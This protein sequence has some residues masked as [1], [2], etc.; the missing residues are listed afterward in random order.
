MK[1]LKLVFVTGTRADYG[2][3]KS[4][5]LL[6]DADKDIEAHVYVT[7]MHLLPEYGFT[8]EDIV[9][10]GYN[11][12]HIPGNSIC[13][14]KMDEN[15][16]H[17]ILH[18]SPYVREI[19]PDFI[20][21]HGDRI[22]PLAGS[23]VGIL[24]NVR[25]AHI[26]GGEITGT[27]D[28][29][30]RHAISKLSHLHFVANEESKIRLL[31]L[32]E[33]ENSIYAIGSPDIDI[34]LSDA[35]PSVT[36]V[37]AKYGIEFEEYSICIYHPVTTSTNLEHETQEVVSALLTSNKN[38]IVIYPNND[39]G[40]EIIRHSLNTL[41]E[42]ERFMFFKSIPFEYFLV[43]LKNSE[44]IIGNSSAGVREACVYGV[45]AIDIG[46]R[47]NKR[48]VPGALKNIQHTAEDCQSIL[49]CIAQI[50][51][52]RH[53]S[54]YFGNGQSA[55]LFLDIIKSSAILEGDLQKTFV[56]LDVTSDAIRNYINEV[57]F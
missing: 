10:D 20:V 11:N 25:V 24:N 45:P 34:M 26:E 3:L 28:E 30:M 47:Q 56:E 31:Q 35:L 53:H 39:H 42:C 18:F 6:C 4:L 46:S 27:V 9:T 51:N 7:G 21:V 32:G 23:I 37:K 40:S 54:N 22:E 15:L 52:Y 50:D 41:N 16:A 49:N 14:D 44:C 2:K 29:L 12:I 19:K 48:Y 38:Y 1:K 5:M 13:S 57:C 43:L 55:K 8:Y 17:T 36:E 33:H